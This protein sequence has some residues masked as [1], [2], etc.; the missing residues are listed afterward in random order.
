MQSSSLAVFVVLMFGSFLTNASAR[1]SGIAE[2]QLRETAACGEEFF[3]N[4]YKG[5]M[6]ELACERKESNAK[7]CG[8]FMALTYTRNA[9][10]KESE[11]IT[12]I[13]PPDVFDIANTIDVPIKTYSPRGREIFQ[14]LAAFSSCNSLL[15]AKKALRRRPNDIAL[16]RTVR[17]LDTPRLAHVECPEI[18]PSEQ[19]MKK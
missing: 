6:F 12:H 15:E 8:Y 3:I 7:G 10:L 4:I 18:L 16:Q 5:N 2:K 13:H 1:P 19:P 14:W 11:C 17:Q 9:S